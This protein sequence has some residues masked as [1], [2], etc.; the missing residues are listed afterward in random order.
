MIEAVDGVLWVMGTKD[1]LRFDGQR[2]E[3]IAFPGN[4]PVR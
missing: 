3:R 1:L 4:D 2:W